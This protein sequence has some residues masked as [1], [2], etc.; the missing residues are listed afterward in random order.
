MKK[1]EK[2]V[3]SLGSI[4][5]LQKKCKER[6]IELLAKA[7]INPEEFYNRPSPTPQP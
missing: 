5:L 1:H 4:D 3:S 2:I 7:G 6:E